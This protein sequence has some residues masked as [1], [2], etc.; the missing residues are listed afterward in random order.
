MANPQ[1]EDGHTD[2]A[3]EILEALWKINLSA[4]ETRV[5]I[6]LL[7][8]T[9]GW[10]KKVDAI[11]LSQFEKAIGLDRR[12]IHRT[13][14]ELSSKG[15]IVVIPQ[16]DRKPVSY[17]FQKD[18]QKWKLSSPKMTHHKGVIPRDDRTVIPQDDA[19]SSQG[20]PTKET[21]TKETKK[22]HILPEIKIFIDF[23]YNNFK[24]K[25]GTPPAIQGAKDAATIKRLLKQTPLEELKTLLLR[26]FDS[27]DSFIIGSGYTI[28]VF[29]SQINKLKIG[30]KKQT[31]KVLR[32]LQK[33]YEEMKDGERKIPLLD[34]KAG[35]GIQ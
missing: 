6:F 31:P 28:G 21:N 8:K 27:D 2:I 16:D 14:K 17:G 30:E 10:H 18:Y 34:D 19:L 26:M 29:Q 20:I 13:L 9:Y 22:K 23:Y 32:G 33:V 35:P 24:E 11:S 12:L 15:M 5:L 1:A 3:N 25:F 7:R 4:Y